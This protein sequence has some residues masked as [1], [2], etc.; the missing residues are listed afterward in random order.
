MS[1]PPPILSIHDAPQAGEVAPRAMSAVFLD[2][3]RRQRQRAVPL[4][5]EQE[6][7]DACEQQAIADAVEGIV[8]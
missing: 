4:T 1:L 7:A 6:E 5:P 2:G 8:P 3:K